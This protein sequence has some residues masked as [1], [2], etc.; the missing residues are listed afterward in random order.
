MNYFLDREDW[1]L[2]FH[3]ICESSSAEETLVCQECI[4]GEVLNFHVCSLLDPD[5]GNVIWERSQEDKSTILQRTIS[6]SQVR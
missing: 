1:G 4:D 6:M 3:E 5:N 2:D